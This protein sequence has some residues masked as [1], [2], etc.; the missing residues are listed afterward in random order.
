MLLPQFYFSFFAQQNHRSVLSTLRSNLSPDVYFQ[1]CSLEDSSVYQPWDGLLCFYEFRSLC[2]KLGARSLH[3][4]P[5]VLFLM[6]FCHQHS[7]VSPLTSHFL[8]VVKRRW[9]VLSAS[10]LVFF[11][12]LNRP[13]CSVHRGKC[14]LST[15]PLF[16]LPAVI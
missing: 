7:I 16:T 4:G 14:D 5:M 1:R 2:R 13:P 11:N 9:E 8:N 15:T 3:L 12:R 10:L 6:F